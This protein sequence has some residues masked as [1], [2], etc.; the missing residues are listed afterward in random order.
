MS[1]KCE[2]NFVF[3]TPSFS[4]A[5][6]HNSTVCQLNGDALDLWNDDATIL[7]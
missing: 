3:G 7:N 2:D 4:P 5:I 1:F 6:F